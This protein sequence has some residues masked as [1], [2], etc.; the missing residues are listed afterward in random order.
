ME[1]QDG[2]SVSFGKTQHWDERYTEDT[3][4]F[5]WYLRWAALAA[6]V[7]KKIRKDMEVL[8]CGCGNSRMGADMIQDGYKYVLGVDISLVCVRQ[9]TE[10][11]RESDLNG[12]AF[13]H[14]N[15]CALELPD[16]SFDA[17]IAKATVDVLMCGE[18]AVRNVHKMCHE[19]SRVLRPG[20]VFFVVS[21]DDDYVQYLDPEKA[22]QEFGWKVAIEK[23]P[24]PVMN[25]KIPAIDHQGR[26]LFYYVYICTKKV[27]SSG[28]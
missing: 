17:A 15:A 11:Y 24:K 12:L 16:E 19:V 22:N 21:H 3:A 5:D 14:M 26:L 25:P 23:I 13:L 18:G 6:V 9:M 10:R 4:Q 27:T 20:G 8:N 1:T 7:E 2:S 28:G